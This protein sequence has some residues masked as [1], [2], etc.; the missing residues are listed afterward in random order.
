MMSAARSATVTSTELGTRQDEE[1]EGLLPDSGHIYLKQVKLN[2]SSSY[3]D[4]D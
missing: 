2:F 3:S 1:E 4:S